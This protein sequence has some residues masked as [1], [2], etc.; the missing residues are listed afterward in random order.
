MASVIRIVG[1]LD[2]DGIDQ[3]SAPE[4]AVI[5]LLGIL[6]RT[7]CGVSRIEPPGFVVEVMTYGDLGGTAAH[8]TIAEAFQDQAL[9]GWVWANGP[10]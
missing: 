1:E 10:L 8:R 5:R 3:P 2:L 4:L 9:D 6:P 7:W